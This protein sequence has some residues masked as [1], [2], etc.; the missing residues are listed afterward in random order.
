MREYDV[1]FVIAPTFGDAKVAEVRDYVRRTITDLGG[2][3]Q[4]E[5]DWGLR[6]FPYLVKKYRQGQWN[7]WKCTLPSEA[8]N[9]LAFD[10][11]IREGIIRHMITLAVE[12]SKRYRNRLKKQAAAGATPAAAGQSARA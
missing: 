11:R 12:P 8:P 5:Q 1:I 6:P 10:L 4:E 3:V 9:R 7:Y 2:S